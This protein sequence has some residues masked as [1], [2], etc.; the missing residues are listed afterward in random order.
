MAGNAD[1]GRVRR[2][3]SRNPKVTEKAKP[4]SK[5]RAKAE[6]QELLSI[7]NICSNDDLGKQSEYF[8][9]SDASTNVVMSDVLHELARQIERSKT[10]PE[11]VASK[12]EIT[13]NMKLAATRGNVSQEPSGTKV[14]EE[15]LK[16][17]SKDLPHIVT[18]AAAIGEI[19]KEDDRKQD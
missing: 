12:I 18:C 5:V 1:I 2:R 4:S 9:G 14:T 16:S 7:D 15:F 6:N 8:S 17:Y 13:K 19:Q 10:E 3:R 11:A